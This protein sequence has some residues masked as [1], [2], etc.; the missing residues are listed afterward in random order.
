MSAGNGGSRPTC[1]APSPPA[2]ATRPR[3]ARQ[4]WML[5]SWCADAQLPELTTLAETIE[6]WWPAVLVFLRTG[7][8]NARTYRPRVPLHC[9]RHARRMPARNQ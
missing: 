8:T 5:Y 4:L 6:T 9:T 2:A 7:L 1:A 3:S